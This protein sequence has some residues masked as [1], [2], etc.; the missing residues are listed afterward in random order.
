VHDI[1]GDR[2][3]AA[4]RQILERT[5]T[6][7]TPR[8]P[9]GY[10]DL[11]VLRALLGAAPELD[12]LLRPYTTGACVSAALRHALEHA[13][14]ATSG[15]EAGP[16]GAAVDAVVARAVRVADDFVQEDVT[17]AHLLM[18]LLDRPSAPAAS[19]LRSLGRSLPTTLDA[20]SVHLRGEL[21]SW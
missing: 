16:A 4:T 3:D 6:T 18:A 10:E 2:L 19:C 7:L 12:R 9:P 17:S 14:R 21:R 15:S 20:I 5:R 8:V 13:E 1:A 11:D